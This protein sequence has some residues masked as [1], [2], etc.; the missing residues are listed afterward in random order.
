LSLA[1]DIALNHYRN[2]YTL[3]DKLNE[4]DKKYEQPSKLAVNRK[5]YERIMEEEDKQIEE[6]DFELERSLVMSRFESFFDG[7]DEN[8]KRKL[9][10]K[11]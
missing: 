5:K 8:T 9:F 3:K 6:P 4:L 11:H 2:T 7:L 10:R 1:D